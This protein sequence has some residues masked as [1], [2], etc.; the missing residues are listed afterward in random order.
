MLVL[1]LQ[2]SPRKKGNTSFLLSTFLKEAEN[3]GA[4]TD[5]IELGSKNILPCQ[6]CGYCEKKGT[7]VI[8][9][10]MNDYIFPLFRRAEVIVT[11]TP[12]FFYSAPAQLKILIDRCQTLWSR[13]Y[14]LNLHDPGSKTRQGFLLALGATRGKNLFK[15]I[16]LTA[17][18]FFDAIG[19][20][21]G[22]SLT[23]WRIEKAGDMERHPT[24]LS[25]VQEKIDGLLKPFLNRRKILFVCR[26]NA[27]R[28]QMAAAFGRYF[29]GDKMEV[30]S[31]GSNPAAKVSPV[32]VEV[33]EEKGLDVAFC[34]PG[35]VGE[36]IEDG[37]PDLVISM[38]C[39]DEC[40]F[41][42]GAAREE[43]NLPDPAGQPIDF[44][45]NIR[46]EIEKKVKALLSNMAGE[47][48]RGTRF[49]KLRGM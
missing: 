36:A 32:M 33:M 43:W 37:R 48:G 27:C 16:N 45:R 23:Y 20:S 38:G 3:L 30:V 17:K 1:G 49:D 40:P 24:V 31:G 41:I 22:G 39:G 8:E 12:I 18:Y 5:I 46:D 13:K 7:C 42:P 15:G 6:G 21:Y 14:K 29:A 26:E 35:S 47:E 19:A 44:M 34:R 9:D 28:S 11:A 25:D 2:G 4:Q 10:E